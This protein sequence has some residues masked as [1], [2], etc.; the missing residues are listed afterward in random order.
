MFARCQY[1]ARIGIAMM[2]TVVLRQVRGRALGIGVFR[3]EGGHEFVL[4]GGQHRFTLGI[5]AG[6]D[7]HP[8][9]GGCRAGA[10]P[11][12]GAHQGDI[13]VEGRAHFAF[14]IPSNPRRR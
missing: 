14:G 10:A 9:Q 5:L 8:A 6:F 3:S 13:D 7:Q 2:I 11:I 4:C 12:V 1:P